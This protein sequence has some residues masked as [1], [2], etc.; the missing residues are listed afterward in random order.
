MSARGVQMKSICIADRTI[1]VGGLPQPIGGVTTFLRR[2]LM[3]NLGKVV[4]F[5]DLYPS[6]DKKVPASFMGTYYAASSKLAAWLNLFL[7]L[8]KFRSNCVF[9][10]NFSRLR[11]ICVFAFLPKFKGVQWEL[12]L[13]HGE[14]ATRLPHWFVARV[15]RRFDKIYAIGQ[16]QHSA[17]VSYGLKTVHMASSYVPP[18]IEYDGV[19][20]LVKK[21]VES[22]MAA[23]RRLI[24]ASGFPRELYRHDIAM[25][26]CEHGNDRALMLFL[27]GDGELKNYFKE[28]NT[29]NII[30]FWDTPENDFNYALS[31]ASL[32][33]RPTS[34]DSFGIACADAVSF[35]VPVVASDV[36]TRARGVVTCAVGSGEEFIDLCNRAI[37]LP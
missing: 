18:V 34:K 17:Y 23:G 10:F 25:R 7:A 13:H 4:A 16:N 36:C 2:L 33:V 3:I 1:I 29:S 5:V 21:S 32:Y 20:S 12:M 22:V 28:L 11:S 19:S 27:Y 15:L 14:L 37:L 24:V 6:A 35:G 26:L 31:C 30:V 9:F 8:S